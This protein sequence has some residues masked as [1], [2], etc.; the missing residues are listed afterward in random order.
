MTAGDGEVVGG[1]QVVEGVE[2]GDAEAEGVGV[3]RVGRGRRRSP[4]DVVEECGMGGLWEPM[5]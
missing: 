1:I 3:V 2:E 5:R 4:G